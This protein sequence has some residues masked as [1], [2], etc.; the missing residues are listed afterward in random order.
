MFQY[1]K[2][3]LCTRYAVAFL[4][5]LSGHCNVSMRL[6]DMNL[7]WSEQLDV[8]NRPMFCVP[9]DILGDWLHCDV[10]EPWPLVVGMAKQIMLC[11]RSPLLLRAIKEAKGDRAQVTSQSGKH[12][13]HTK[14]KHQRAHDMN[15]SHKDKA[16]ARDDRKSRVR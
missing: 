12:Q 13:Q 15:T 14:A 4:V 16:V 2:Y 7:L 6:C 8:M 5:V 3:I 11:T 10:G 1:H 9:Q